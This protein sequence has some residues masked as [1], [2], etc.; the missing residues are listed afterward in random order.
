MYLL[1]GAVQ[2]SNLSSNKSVEN[3]CVVAF[4][5][6]RFLI[7]PKGSQVG[8]EWF[9]R[10]CF[11]LYEGTGG[12]D[13]SEED[14]FKSLGRKLFKFVLRNYTTM[15][16]NDLPDSDFDAN[17]KRII[18]VMHEYFMRY[19]FPSLS[20]R[21]DFPEKAPSRD[22]ELQKISAD[23]KK[24]GTTTGDKLFGYHTKDGKPQFVLIHVEAHGG[25][26]AP[27]KQQQF[28]RYY[29]LRDLHLEAGITQLV[30]YI[31][32]TVP[33]QPTRHRESFEGTVNI[34]RFNAYF[35]RK[36]D[37][38]KLLEDAQTNPMALVI[39]AL[40]ENLKTKNQAEHRRK[41][42]LRLMRLCLE[43]PFKNLTEQLL[44]FVDFTIALPKNDELIFQA[45]F[46]QILEIEMKPLIETHPE[47]VMVKF[48]Q[49]VI[50]DGKLYKE[51][52]DEKDKETIVK[53]YE[54][55][56]SAP[57]IAHFIKRDLKFVKDVIQEIKKRSADGNLA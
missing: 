48:Y 22:K 57:K 53:M 44:N 17:I 35:V 40:L 2:P 39:L 13:F 24:A 49:R 6:P 16:E 18:E 47:S 9:R 52:L 29:R 31:G 3:G 42:K 15:N 14:F 7:A 4:G 54:G 23:G 10:C 34:H 5:K 1:R 50:F 20:E 26:D 46:N 56:I 19:F 12:A 8:L 32:E 11:N 27:F 55:G 43:S 38:E 30:I 41:T 37:R 28:K 45:E 25:D 21:L 33:P 51:V 36:Q